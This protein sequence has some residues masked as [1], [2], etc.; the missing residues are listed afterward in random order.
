MSSKLLALLL[1]LAGGEDHFGLSVVS[2]E[3]TLAFREQALL[4]V[5]VQTIEKDTGEDPPGDVEQRNASVV[6][7]EFSVRLPLVEMDDGR[8]FQILRS[9][10]LAPHLME[11]FS[12]P[13]LGEDEAVI[14]PTVGIA[15]RLGHEHLLSIS[16]PDENIVQQ[17]PAP[18]PRVH[19][20]GLLPHWKAEEGVG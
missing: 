20:R 19:P 4:W 6:S 11:S 13:H 3:A 16:P 14:R 15:D 2:L 1:Q 10:S 7:T 5:T 12:E 9:L 8:V 18:L 17:L